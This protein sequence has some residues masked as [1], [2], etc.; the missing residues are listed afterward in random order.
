LLFQKIDVEVGAAEF[1]IGDAL[2]ADRLLLFD[3]I[4][5]VIVFYFAQFIFGNFAMLVL[6]A[7]I[8]QGLGPQKAANMVSAIG[9][10]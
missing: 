3:D 2:Q 9:R 8:Q 6:F 7:R 1:A 4:R 5:D 10:V